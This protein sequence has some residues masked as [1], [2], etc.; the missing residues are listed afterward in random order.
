MSRPASVVSSWASMVVTVSVSVSDSSSAYTTTPVSSLVSLVS[1]VSPAQFA[2]AKF[3]E[4]VLILVPKSARYVK[5]IASR[6]AV[7]SLLSAFSN[8]SSGDS[9][10]GM[11]VSYLDNG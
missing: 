6:S 9:Y 2:A 5:R 8:H 4:S 10:P 3:I 7:R 11:S 1:Q